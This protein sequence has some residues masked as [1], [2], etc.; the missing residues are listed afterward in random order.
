[1]GEDV[2]LSLR[3][4]LGLGQGQGVVWVIMVRNWVMAPGG[5]VSRVSF[6]TIHTFL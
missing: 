4:E 6:R 2:A 1:M 3:L 5:P